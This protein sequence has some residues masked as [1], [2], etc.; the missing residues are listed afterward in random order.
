MIPA[1]HYVTHVLNV[2]CV[3]WESNPFY[4]GNFVHKFKKICIWKSESPNKV[5]RIMLLFYA[6]LMNFLKCPWNSI[7]NWSTYKTLSSFSPILLLLG[8][9]LI[10]D[11]STFSP[12]FRSYFF[13]VPSKC[14]LL[15]CTSPL[16]S[17]PMSTNAPKW[18]TF[19]TLPVTFVPTFKL[20]MLFMES[21]NSGFSNS[22]KSKR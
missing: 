6:S 1:D 18:V 11:V 16:F 12:I 20:D 3:W 15:I 5:C 7:C 4:L 19:V 22:E 2:Q 10:M 14:I 21:L 9:K 13:L 8:S 17:T